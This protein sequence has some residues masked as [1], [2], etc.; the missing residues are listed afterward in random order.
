MSKAL[1][2]RAH[3]N[4]NVVIGN[5]ATVAA[6]V[7]AHVELIEHFKSDTAIALKSN[8]VKS[9][10]PGIGSHL[11]ASRSTVVHDRVGGLVSVDREFSVPAIQHSDGRSSLTVKEEPIHTSQNYTGL[12]IRADNVGQDSG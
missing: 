11:G 6:N 1:G 12:S 9:Q 2:G 3:H 7:L 4:P 5:V 10:T 8:V